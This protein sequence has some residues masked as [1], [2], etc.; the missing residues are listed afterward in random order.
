MY[1]EFAYST[2]M[3]VILAAF[4]FIQTF[5]FIYLIADIILRVYKENARA[6]QKALYAC[7]TGTIL[8][9]CWI[10]GVYFVL[11]AQDF[12]ALLNLLITT[13]NPLFAVLYYVFGVKALK[14]SPVR[15]FAF[16]GKIYQHHMVTRSINRLLG[17]IFYIWYPMEA[18][19]YNYLIDFHIQLICLIFFLMFYG[20]LRALLRLGILRA[21]HAYYSVFNS[22]KREWT[23]YIAKCTFI[24][25]CYI[26][27]P[28]SISDDR[29]IFANTLLLLVMALF[30]AFSVYYEYNRA[31][32]I[33]ISNRDA[34]IKTLS[35]S[36]E[37]AHGLRHDIRNILNTYGGYL[38]LGDL[39]RLRTYHAATV[40]KLI[41]PDAPDLNCRFE[42]N[43]AFVSLLSAKAAYAGS[44]GVTLRYL[45]TCDLRDFFI[46]NLDLCRIIGNLADNAIEAAA[47]S[48]RKI[49]GLTIGAKSENDKLIVIMNSTKA[50]VDIE[51]IQLLGETTK[52]G[53]SGIGLPCVRKIVSNYGHC[54]FRITYYDYEFTAYL[55]TRR[56]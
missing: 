10:Y 41:P 20:S 31:H 11:G 17:S 12:P 54:V 53:H 52:A 24:Y 47:E 23:T 3:Q 49:A 25:A 9:N 30:Y 27:I 48:E 44:L 32:V 8:H 5:I 50:P 19:R 6:S 22:L 35:T 45:F 13:P 15:S 28:Y 36:L 21:T 1:D 55:E 46:D 40:S 51:C 16:M 2:Q 14:F 38:S 42:E 34:H 37:E 56:V 26:M 33:D 18:G 7:L 29:D 39:N 4:T 43:P